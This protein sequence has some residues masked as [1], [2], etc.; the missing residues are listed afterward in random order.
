MDRTSTPAWLI[1]LACS[2]HAA[3]ASLAEC[4]DL[5]EWFGV[6]RTRAAIHHWYQPFAEHY[7][8]DFTAEPDRVAVD[9]KQ[10]QLENEQKV[11]L[12]AAIDVDSKVVLHARLSQNRGTE[13]ATTFL[14]ELKE[15]SYSVK[16]MNRKT[17]ATCGGSDEEGVKWTNSPQKRSVLS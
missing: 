15:H 9:E 10:I 2:A 8:Q 17:T 1:R 14:R 4:R 12:Y 13:P 11:W 7:D 5:C 16:G 3:A 6:S